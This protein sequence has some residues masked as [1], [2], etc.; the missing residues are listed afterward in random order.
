MQRWWQNLLVG[1]LLGAM[2][3]TVC[4]HLAS[5]KGDIRALDA[6]VSKLE[7]RRVAGW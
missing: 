4:W 5:T 3:A 7:S 6:R 2:L 1:L